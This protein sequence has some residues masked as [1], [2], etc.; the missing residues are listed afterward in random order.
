MGASK[1]EG[2]HA[3]EEENDIVETL[4]S[5]RENDGVIL[6]DLDGVNEKKRVAVEEER[7]R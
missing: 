2:T 6:P 3:V 4:A 7:A 1:R 5:V